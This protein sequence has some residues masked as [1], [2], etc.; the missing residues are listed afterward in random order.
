MLICEYKLTSEWFNGEKSTLQKR[1]VLI[2][3][4][5]EVDGE[6]WDPQIALQPDL[7]KDQQDFFKFQSN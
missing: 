3:A 7:Q 4:E 6:E 2:K 5:M 1:R